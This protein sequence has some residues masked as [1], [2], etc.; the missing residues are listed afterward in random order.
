MSEMLDYYTL[1]L[2]QVKTPIAAMHLLLQELDDG[3]RAALDAGCS[4]SSSIP[5]WR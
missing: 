5:T 4:R 2:H 1:W 3:P